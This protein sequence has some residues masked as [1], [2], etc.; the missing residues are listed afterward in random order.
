[1]FCGC[2]GISDE[3]IAQNLI[4]Q[5]FQSLRG[6]KEYLF[7][8]LVKMIRVIFVCIFS[9]FPI[10]KHHF[11][12]VSMSLNQKKMILGGITA[13]RFSSFLPILEK[14]ALL[15]LSKIENFER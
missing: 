7:P 15:R 9:V 5:N 11:I 3:H 8:K 4:S 1:M 6:V 2:N 12:A 10:P 14:G 13:V